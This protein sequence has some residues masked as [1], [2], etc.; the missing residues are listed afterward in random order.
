MRLVR[1]LVFVVTVMGIGFAIGATNQ[2][3]SWY[4]AL[5]KPAFNPPNWIFAPV[6]TVVYI[7]MAIA[8]WRT[9]E[10]HRASAA[11]A[12]WFAQLVLNFCW[13]PIF[14]AAQSPSIALSVILMLLVAIALFIANTW[15][16]DKV[17][18][19]LFIPYAAWVTFA[20]ILNYEIM[21]LN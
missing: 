3:G 2:P 10:R 4:A 17:S 14:F 13:S 6:W 12:L 20:S 15:S 9:W 16:S 11:M 5:A 1:L 7:L 19:A 8:G 18:A 21:R